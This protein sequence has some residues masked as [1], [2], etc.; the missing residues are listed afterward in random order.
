MNN[1]LKVGDKVIVK[2]SGRETERGTV[3]GV[4][5]RPESEQWINTGVYF[6]SIKDDTDTR[7][8]S[9]SYNIFEPDKIWIDV[10]AQRDKKLN[11]ILS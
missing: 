4:H 6:Y 2:R 9:W 5:M 1:T 11:E 3:C 7:T 10:E 8:Y